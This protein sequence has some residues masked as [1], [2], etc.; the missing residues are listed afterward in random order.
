MVETPVLFI[1]FARPDYARQSFDAIKAAKPKKLY[2]YSNK[3]RKEKEGE[4]DRNDMVRAFIG[5]V[6]WDCELHTWFRKEYVDVY[7]SLLGAKQWAFKNEDRLIML[8]EDCLASIAFFQFCDHFL[9]VYQNDY[10]INYIT[11]NNYAVGYKEDGVDHYIT[12][13]IHH[14]GWAIWKNR[15]DSIDFSLLPKTIVN[16]GSLKKYYNDDITQYLYFKRHYLGIS[17]FVKR[18]RCWDYV[19]VFNQ[20]ACNSYAVT[21]L[22]NLVQNIGVKGAHEI[23]VE[24]MQFEID[25]GAAKGNY[26]F[27]GDKTSH[28]PNVSYDKMEANKEGHRISVLRYYIGEI[29]HTFIK[30]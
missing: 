29:Y 3:G 15:W 14:H 4:V 5:E 20:I 23:G 6:D 10:R 19:K 26:P 13:S 25:N 16:N 1:T 30:R 17:D 24:K 8:E 9:D 28:I 7:T 22:Y 2:F 27:C 18:T 11:G 21:P 12:R